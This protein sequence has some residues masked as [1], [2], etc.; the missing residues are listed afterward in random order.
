MKSLQIL[1]TASLAL[2]AFNTMA[3]AETF[4]IFEDA[5]GSPTANTIT[6]AA[7]KAKTI[8]ISGKSSAFINFAVSSGQGDPVFNINPTSVTGARLVIFLTKASTTGTLTISNLLSGFTESS[9]TAIPT[10]TIGAPLGTIPLASFTPSLNADYFITDITAQVKAWLTNFNPNTEFGIAIT[11]DGTATATLASK[12]GAGSGHP[13]FIEVDINKG[14]GTVSGTTAVFTGGVTA[15]SFSS[16]GA[17]SGTT[18]TFSG[19]LTSSSA[20]FS[21]PVSI[22]SAFVV[23]APPNN[24]GT[25]NLFAGPGAGSGNTTG[26]NN[27]AFGDGALASNQNGGGNLALGNSSLH[28]SVSGSSNTAVGSGALFNA[29]GTGNIALGL[30]AGV[31]ITSTNNNIDI[32]SPGS[33]GDSGFIRLGTAGTH[34]ATT[35][36]GKVGINTGSLPSIATLEVRH[37]LSGLALDV[38]F[39]V[40]KGAGTQVLTCRT[41]IDGGPLNLELFEGEAFKPGGGAWGVVSDR[42]LKKDIEPLNGALDHLMKLRSVTYEYIDP[43]KSH[44]FAGTQTGF[45]AQEVETVF[46]E[47][48]TENA[49]GYKTVTIRGFESLTVQALRELRAEKDAEIAA[50]KQKLAAL[51]A[52][53]AAREARL[54]RLESALDAAS[55]RP[56]RASLDFKEAPPSRVFPPPRV[57]PGAARR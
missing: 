51:E 1:R 10:P 43:V 45:I 17:L 23:D 46:P 5:A 32:G 2:A 54:T 16:T 42:R 26:N 37:A 55:D 31:S 3:W 38:P 20:T 25:K 4:P 12:E 48:V 24:T 35:L 40:T 29:T 41:F 6:A 52:R 22:G 18:G 9:T 19:A 11:S 13:A 47:W 14:G 30:N 57:P 27:A 53:D 50:L 15:G 49:D 34:T 33:G 39:Q 56:V 44:Q 7:G 28:A 8:A 21:G 36:V